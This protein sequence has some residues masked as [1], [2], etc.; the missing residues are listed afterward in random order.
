MLHE[1]TV[2][3]VLARLRIFLTD[4]RTSLIHYRICLALTEDSRQKGSKRAPRSSNALLPPCP[5]C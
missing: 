2:R 4:L 1:T 5:V 3:T